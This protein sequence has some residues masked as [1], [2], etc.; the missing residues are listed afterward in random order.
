MK[1]KYF[2][3]ELFYSTI[4]TA[5]NSYCNLTYNN[6]GDEDQKNGQRFKFCFHVLFDVKFY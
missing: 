2:I 6:I 4:I 1:H 5:R 3:F